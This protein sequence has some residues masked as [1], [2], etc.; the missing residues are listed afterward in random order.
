MIATACRRT[1]KKSDLSFERS[2]STMTGTISAFLEVE[3]FVA[4]G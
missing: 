4:R 2:L 1:L 3:S